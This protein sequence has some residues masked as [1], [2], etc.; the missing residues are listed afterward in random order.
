MGTVGKSVNAWIFLA[1]DDPAGTSYKSPTSEYQSLITY[2]VYNYVDMVN[3]CFVDTVPTSAATV[4]TGDGSSCTVQLGAKTHPDGSSNQDYMD[5][6]IEDARAANPGIKILVTLAYGDPDELT[7][8]FSSDQSQ[9]QQN[10]SDFADNLV[11]YLQHYGLDGFDIDWESPLSGN[12]SPQQFAILFAAVRKAFDAAGTYYLTLSP[13]DV[14]TLDAATVNSAFDFVSLQLYSGFTTASEFTQAGVLQSQ[15][16]YGAK[17]ESN[18]EWDLCP[19]QDAQNAYQQYTAGGYTIAT[20][21]RLNSGNYQYEQAQQMLLHQLVHGISASAFDD[22][23]I[24]G[25]AG[26][27]PITRMVVRSGNVLD[28]IQATNTGSFSGCNKPLNYVLPQHGGKGGQA[29]NVAIAPGDAIVGISGYTG[30][31]FGWD[32]VLQLTIT[33]RGGQVFGP[34]GTMDNATSKTAFSCTAPAGQSILAFSGTAVEVPLAGGGTTWVIAS[35]TP[36]YG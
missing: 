31:W 19:H 11:A 9:W 30:T 35:L 16:Q 26:N 33:T 6:M 22:T 36:S 27:V 25:A 1:E 15:L 10:A 13:A 3:I 2:G 12:G 29:S 21:W 8:I 28:A 32:V 20:Q 34:F 23:A 7:R 14:G 24:V 18:S 17:F 4:P 5:W